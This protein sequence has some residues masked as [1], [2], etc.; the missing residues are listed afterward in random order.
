MNGISA[1]SAREIHAPVASSKTASVYSI[2][3]H[4]FCSMLLM[5][6]L[7]AAVQAHGHGHVGAAGHGGPARPVPPKKAESMRTRTC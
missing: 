5:A 1:T 2:G 4:A 7:I 6:V 3:V